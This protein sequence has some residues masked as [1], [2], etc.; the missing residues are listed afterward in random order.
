MSLLLHHSSLSLPILRSPRSHSEG[1]P[2]WPDPSRLP[3][4][5]NRHISYSAWG[6][7]DWLNT[8]QLRNRSCSANLSKTPAWNHYSGNSAVTVERPSRLRKNILAR[9]ASGKG[10][11]GET[12]QESNLSTSRL[13]RMS[14]ASRTTLCG[15]GGLFQHP[16][17]TYILLLV[18]S[19]GCY[20][21]GRPEV[22]RVFPHT[23][24]TL[25]TNLHN[26]PP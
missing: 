8:I 18:P 2:T 7:G 19:V 23:L 22:I 1:F 16:A 12:R 15:A 3:A 6:R 26:T 5:R 17:K 20:S 13:S 4:D 10:E 9:E 14:R 24:L 25:W 11:T 21:R